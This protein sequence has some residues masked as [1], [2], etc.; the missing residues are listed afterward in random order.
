MGKTK[1]DTRPLKKNKER[2]ARSPVRRVVKKR[3]KVQT[4]VNPE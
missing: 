1:K 3:Q 2:S 4:V